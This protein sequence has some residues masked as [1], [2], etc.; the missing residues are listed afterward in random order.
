MNGRHDIN[1]AYS[2]GGRPPARTYVSGMH[3]ASP[4]VDADFDLGGL[5]VV[6]DLEIAAAAAGAYS[7]ES[8]SSDE[9]SSSGAGAC[10]PLPAACCLH[11]PL[12]EPRARAGTAA[13][14]DSD[15]SS[16][17]EGGSSSSSEGE[18]GLEPSGGAV[19][20]SF[21]WDGA[22]VLHPP[23]LANAAQAAG[24][25]MGTALLRAFQPHACALR[26]PRRAAP[27]AGGARARGGRAH[28]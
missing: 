27:G 1:Q 4:G 7:T 19:A 22:R 18:E 16:E 5:P 9:G 21:S 14:S 20:L 24:T 23:A 12:P 15:S 25:A 10:G 6:D 2:Q 26:R 13:E 28:G 8:E 17:D 11:V 3:P